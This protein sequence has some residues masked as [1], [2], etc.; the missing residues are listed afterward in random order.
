MEVIRSSIQRSPF[1]RPILSIAKYI[2]AIRQVL[3]A[4]KVQLLFEPGR[5]IAA[6]AGLLVMRVKY[7]KSTPEHHFALVDAAMNDMLRPALYQALKDIQKM[8]QTTAGQLAQWDTVGPVC[9]TGD[10]L[11]KARTLAL[12][13]WELLYFFTFRFAPKPPIA[14]IIAH[15]ARPILLAGAEWRVAAFCRQ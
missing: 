5:S 4:L 14:L 7:L 6:N 8:E 13:Q 1:T 10:F 9:E 3:G 12:S 11:G 15:S 2:G